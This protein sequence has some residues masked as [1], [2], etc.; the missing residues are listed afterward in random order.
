M[1]ATV[2]S[3]LVVT[4]LVIAAAFYVA[5]LRYRAAEPDSHGWQA[6][7]Y[8]TPGPVAPGNGKGLLG[9][10]RNTSASQLA[11]L[12]YPLLD[13]YHAI[14]EDSGAILF[15]EDSGSLLSPAPAPS[16]ARPLMPSG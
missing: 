5:V 6:R 2:V 14:A 1:D 16:T 10:R 3:A 15:D 12:A 7:H 8:S 11:A 9:K 4:S 13:H